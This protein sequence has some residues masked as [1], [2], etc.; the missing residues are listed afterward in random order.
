MDMSLGGY[1]IILTLA[2]LIVYN[3]VHVEMVIEKE[4]EILQKQ[5]HLF[6]FLCLLLTI[7]MQ[8]G[9]A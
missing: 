5:V 1:T 2:D 6:V 3:L 9:T 4:S 7:K 8:C